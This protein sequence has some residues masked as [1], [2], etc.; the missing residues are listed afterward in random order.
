VSESM[1]IR[2]GGGQVGLVS[3]ALMRDTP[4]A[5]RATVMR[6]R[7]EDGVRKNE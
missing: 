7:F 2:V 4:K 3:R 5:K 6:S 1:S